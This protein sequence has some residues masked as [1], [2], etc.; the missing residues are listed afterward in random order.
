MSL[1]LKGLTVIEVSSL[2]A[3]PAMG[4]LLFEL[5]AEIIKIEQPVLGDP[6]R[7]VSPWGFLNYNY[8]KRSLSL[9][10]KSDSGKEILYRLIRR[11]KTAVFIENLGPDVPKRLGFSYP[12]LSELSPS[13]IYCSIKGFSAKSEYYE[14]PSFDAVAQAMSGM[15]SL[16]G[17]PNGPPVRIGNHSVD[18]GAAAY[19]AIRV[20]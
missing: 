7:K 1:P 11:K 17:E 16:T 6:S 5:G 8:K 20:L 13:L 9:N 14:R 2:V 3:G 12:I 18:I 19:G 10:L 15:M 4:E